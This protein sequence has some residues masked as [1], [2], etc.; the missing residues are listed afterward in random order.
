MTLSEKILAS[1]AGKA[2][3]AAGDLLHCRVDR[4]MATDITAPLSVEVFRQM[5]AR[6]VHDPA[7]CI[8]INDHFVPA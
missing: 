8:L 7:A 5:G 2:A 4:V 3:A 1:H 6:K